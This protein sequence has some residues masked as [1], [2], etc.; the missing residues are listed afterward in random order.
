MLTTIVLMLKPNKDS[1]IKVSHGESAYASALNIIGSFDQELERKIHDGRG[2]KPLTVSPIWEAPRNGNMLLLKSDKTYR[3]R[4]TGLNENVSN[5]LMSLS[6]KV[7][8]LWIDNTDFDVI[9]IY[10]DN[11]SDPN[12]GQSSYKDMLDYW[13]NIEPPESFT[14]KFLSPTTFRDGYNVKPF[15]VPELVF[16]SLINTWNAHSSY[17]LSFS[18]YDI[19]DLI[20]LSNWNGETRSVILEGRKIPCFIGKFTYRAVENLMEIRQIIGLLSDFA[21]F[22]GV[23]NYTGV[24]TGEVF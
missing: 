2:A 6:S 7:K 22:A 16:G 9:D 3:W 4:L 12:A 1:T 24:W 13:N 5:C 18:K 19:K 11:D 15:P 8:Q 17:E 14:L 21:F 23:G 20:M 10:T